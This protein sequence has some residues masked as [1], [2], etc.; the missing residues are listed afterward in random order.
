VKRDLG[1]TTEDTA[2]DKL[3]RLKTQV[4]RGRLI[5]TADKY[6]ALTDLETGEPSRLGIAPQN[7]IELRNEI[8]KGPVE[9][10]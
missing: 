3:G 8:I 6:L 9:G 5:V 1:T 7:P 4:V 2:Q 10:G